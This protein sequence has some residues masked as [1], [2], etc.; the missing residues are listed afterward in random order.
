MLGSIL[1]I[2]NA[3][4][5]SEFLVQH[6]IEETLKRTV[7]AFGSEPTANEI[8]EV[9]EKHG[10]LSCIII[11]EDNDDTEQLAREWRTHFPA[12]P[13]I[14]ISNDYNR[15]HWWL[16]EI[17]A[18][19]F[20]TELE[21][22]MKKFLDLIGR[23]IKEAELPRLQHS[24]FQEAFKDLIQGKGLHPDFKRHL[25]E[26]PKCQ[27]TVEALANV[28]AERLQLSATELR[29]VFNESHHSSI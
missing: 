13:M 24:E 1:Y 21:Q 28:S 20:E 19:L 29:K 25:E 12:I 2:A 17:E 6:A 16:E 3:G 23:V 18:H 14:V 27:A 4:S 15:N 10:Q 11:A 26:C 9:K 22:S 7:L 5:V 8:L